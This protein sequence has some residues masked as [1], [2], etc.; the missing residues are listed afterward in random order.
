MAFKRIVAKSENDLETIIDN[1]KSWFQESEDYNTEFTKEN[2]KFQDPNTLKIIEKSIDVIKAVD[3]NNGNVASIKFIPMKEKEQMK[4]E[5]GGEGESAVAGKISNQMKGKGVLKSYSKDA[6]KPLKEYSVAPR[7]HKTYRPEELTYPI[8]LKLIDDMYGIGEEDKTI[9][10]GDIFDL[11]LKFGA[12]HTQDK[13]D[14]QIMGILRDNGWNILKETIKVFEL[15]KLIKEEL[16]NF[17]KESSNNLA[18]NVYSN[19]SYIYDTDNLVIRNT[20][21]RLKNWINQHIDEIG[22]GYLPHNLYNQLKPFSEELSEPVEDLV[23]T[24]NFVIEEMNDQYLEESQ[25]QGESKKVKIKVSELKK[26]IK[27]ELKNYIK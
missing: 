1:I 7:T 18:D 19:M 8:I 13:M 26:L 11:V 23:D 14:R 6:K 12:T 3:K 22:D 4:L 21:R 5:I 25:K 17:I 16:N 10:Q 20:L 15:K 27:E 9:S 24:I 2:R